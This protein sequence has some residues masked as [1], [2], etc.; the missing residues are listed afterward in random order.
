MFIA[1]IAAKSKPLSKAFNLASW[2]L[3]ESC[4][5]LISAPQLPLLQGLGGGD[6]DFG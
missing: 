6:G 3:V 4:F 5:L 1:A 2:S